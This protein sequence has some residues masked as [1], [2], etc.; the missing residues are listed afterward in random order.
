MMCVEEL[1]DE[2]Y[3]VPPLH[4]YAHLYT[5]LHSIDTSLKH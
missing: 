2:V 3:K 1:V 5:P 4:P